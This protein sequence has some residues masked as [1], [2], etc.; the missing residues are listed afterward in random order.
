MPNKMKV[1]HNVLHVYRVLKRD[2][3][4][5][6]NGEYITNTKDLKRKVKEVIKEQ[7]DMIDEIGDI[8]Y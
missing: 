6:L 8:R 4:I 3:E 1:I 5:I 7:S 2:G